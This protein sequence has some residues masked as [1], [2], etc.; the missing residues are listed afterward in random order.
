M[1][2]AKINVSPSLNPNTE[3]PY[4]YIDESILEDM[5]QNNK[6]STKHQNVSSFINSCDNSENS[7]VNSF[8]TA[9]QSSVY[10]EIYL[11]PYSSLQTEV[12]PVSYD[13]PSET[14]TTCDIPTKSKDSY[15]IPR[16]ST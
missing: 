6:G 10:R 9:Q 15:D 16:S 4:D 8:E 2:E 7:S 3:R 14:S 11:N 12:K 5:S 13:I 1:G